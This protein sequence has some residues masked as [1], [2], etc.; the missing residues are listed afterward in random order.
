MARWLRRAAVATAIALA[1]LETAAQPLPVQGGCRDG[2]P[3]GAWQLGTVDGQPRALGA[4]A[5]G[6]RTGSFIFWNPAGGRVAHVPFE[7]GTRSGTAAMWFDTA[8]RGV[9]GRQRLEAAYAGGELHGVKRTWYADGRPRGEYVY[10]KGVLGVAR[11]WDARGRVLSDADA[12]AQALSDQDADEALFLKLDA[13]VD[14]HLPRCSAAT[15]LPT[16]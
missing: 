9:D 6:K 4:F 2:A 10:A 11:A 12:K 1:A 15:S 5:K 3:H 13:I 7:D 16:Q 14:A 8:T